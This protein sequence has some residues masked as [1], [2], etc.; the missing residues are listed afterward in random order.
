MRHFLR[1]ALQFLDFEFDKLQV[2]FSLLLRRQRLQIRDVF[3]KLFALRLNRRGNRGDRFR[4]VRSLDSVLPNGLNSRQDAVTFLSTSND[5]RVRLLHGRDDRRAVRRN[6]PFDGV[7][8]S[9]K[10]CACVHKK[11]VSIRYCYYFF[12]YE[13]DSTRGRDDGS[14][15]S[16]RPFSHTRKKRI[17][18]NARL[19]PNSKEVYYRSSKHD[20]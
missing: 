4:R 2:V 1:R 20:A 7:D 14:F 6:Q 19:L 17:L 18:T 12:C 13:D 11:V 8:R 9:L 10:Y 5:F 16:S 15:P 3:R